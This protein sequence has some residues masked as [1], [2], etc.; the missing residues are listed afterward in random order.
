MTLKFKP[1][2]FTKDKEW[3][4][5]DTAAKRAQKKFDA[6]LEGQPVVYGEWYKKNVV[7]E[8]CT[9]DAIPGDDTHRARLVG[10][11]TIKENK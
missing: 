2:D 7:S 8:F 3:V 6:W 1:E 11:E 10:I 4:H 9:G 5:K